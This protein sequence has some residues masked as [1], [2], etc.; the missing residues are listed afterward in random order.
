MEEVIGDGPL[1]APICSPD[2]FPIC[3]SRR[4]LNYDE[5]LFYP[6]TD[7]FHSGVTLET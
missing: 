2:F 7:Y 5:A 1:F 3:Y 6:L 4:V